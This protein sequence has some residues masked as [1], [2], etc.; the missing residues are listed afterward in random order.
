MEAGNY[1]LNHFKPTFHFYTHF[2]ILFPEIN[3]Q[4]VLLNLIS[5]LF[6]LWYNL[7]L[8]FACKTPIQ[9]S[10]FVIATFLS[11]S[12]LLNGSNS[13]RFSDPFFMLSKIPE[14]YNRVFWRTDLTVADFLIRFLCYQ[15]FQKCTI[16]YSGALI[17][18][19]T[20]K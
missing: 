12:K 6:P 15:K 19:V 16:G 8:A 13:G 2:Y 4:S 5:L 7:K 20:F 10:D 9:L 17:L 18:L 11:G 1:Y 14:V 3:W